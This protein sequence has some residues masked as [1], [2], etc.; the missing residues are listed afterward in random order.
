VDNKKIIA[1]KNRNAKLSVE[2]IHE[3]C[4]LFKRG[5]K[6]RS[7]ASKYSYVGLAKSFG[8]TKNQIYNLIKGRSYKHI[9]RD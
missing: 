2:D 4:R 8:I 3:I 6:L 5:R 9:T 1:S 7:V